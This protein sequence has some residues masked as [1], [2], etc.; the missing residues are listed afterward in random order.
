MSILSCLWPTILN[1]DTQE[2][3]QT[4]FKGMGLGGNR[5]FMV[6]KAAGEVL[7]GQSV[8]Y[9]ALG[10]AGYVPYPPG[11]PEQLPIYHDSPGQVVISEVQPQ[12][13]Q[14]AAVDAGK[15][16]VALGIFS[17][18]VLAGVVLSKEKD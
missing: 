18:L 14:T 12:P 1:M 2:W 11:Y 17:L 15:A 9:G 16:L 7:Q 4:H 5:F 10:T 8:Q 13:S 3:P 6:S